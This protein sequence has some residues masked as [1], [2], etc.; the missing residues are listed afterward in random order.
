M[1]H[2]SRRPY[3]LNQK[4]SRIFYECPRPRDRRHFVPPCLQTDSRPPRR[5][6]SAHTRSLCARAAVVIFMNERNRPTRVLSCTAGVR[7]NILS[8][9]RPTPREG[10][11]LAG[12]RRSGAARGRRKKYGIIK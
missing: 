11:S 5:L 2:R 9:D 10:A 12:C 6:G 7:Q 3:Q 4:F 8:D 1:G